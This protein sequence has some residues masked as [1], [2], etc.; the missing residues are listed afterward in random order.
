MAD[1]FRTSGIMMAVIYLVVMCVVTVYSMLLLGYAMRITNIRSFEVMGRALFGRGGDIFVG[2]VLCISCVGTAIAYVNAIAS[3]ARPILR[4]ASGT[5]EYLKSDDGVR[6]I[7]TLVWLVFLLPAIIPKK[8]NS[9]RYI[10]VTGIFFVFYFAATIIV[11][12]CLNG[13]KHGMRDGM[14]FFTSG[15]QAIFGLSI[16][17]FAFMCQGITY[18]VYYEMTPKPC[19][20]Q[21]TVASA[22][23]MSACT[24]LYIMAGVF[25]YLDFGPAIKPS[26]LDNYDPINTPYMMVSYVGMTIKIVA[27][28]CSN[29]VPIRNFVYY[30]LGWNLATTP[31]WLHTIFCIVVSGIILVAGLFIPKVTLAFGLVGSLTGGFISFIFPALFWMYCGNWSMKTVGIWHWLATHFLLLG[32]IVAIVWGTIGTVYDSFI[33]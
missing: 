11:H 30:C 23:G 6:L 10:S 24:L 21:L 9:I 29:W 7:Q 33:A 5:P 32:G 14:A 26:I 28:F 4:V 16:F 2:F 15:N 27:A 25:G 13:F 17:I 3:I 12:S 20:R 19:V 22:V 1:S 31:Y 18:S 8:L